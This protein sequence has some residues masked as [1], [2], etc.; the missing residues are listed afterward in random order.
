MLMTGW[1][2]K[3]NQVSIPCVFQNYMF[4]EMSWQIKKERG[5]K[6]DN[7]QFVNQLRL[8]VAIWFDR[9]KT[10]VNPI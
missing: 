5:E 7:K 1:E 8:T 2:N 4:F 9:K 3:T 10:T 6:M